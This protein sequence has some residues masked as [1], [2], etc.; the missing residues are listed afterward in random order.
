M[1]WFKVD[2]AL[3]FHVK[4]ITAG[5][6][7]MG[8]WVRAGSWCAQQLT[9]GHVPANIVR[10]FGGSS[11]DVRSLC[12]VGLWHEVED[13]Y[14]FHDW[15]EYQPTR[16]KVLLDRAEAR[17]RMADLRKRSGE[18]P[19]NVRP[20]NSRSSVTPSRPVPSPNT[21]SREGKKNTTRRKPETSLPE[22]WSHTAKHEEQAKAEGLSITDEVFRFRNHAL[23]ND[24]RARD[25]D[26]AFRVWL[27]KAKDFKPDRPKRQATQSDGRPMPEAWQ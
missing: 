3:A 21:S 6:T 26:A 2:D 12:D 11:D 17:K 27:S 18:H 10:T 14:Q 8:L 16:E 9:N 1:A 4:V 25:W 24:R 15:D 13:G 19:A 7:A 20:N 22:A 23:T 5:N